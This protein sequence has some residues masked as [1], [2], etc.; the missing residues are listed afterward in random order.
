VLEEKYDW[1]TVATQEL[2]NIL[3]QLKGQLL[4]TQILFVLGSVWFQ[5]GT[6]LFSVWFRSVLGN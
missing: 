5:N 6:T 4:P 3:G 2:P 1:C